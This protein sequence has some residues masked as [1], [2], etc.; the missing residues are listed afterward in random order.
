MNRC[1]SEITQCGPG[2]LLPGPGLMGLFTGGRGRV[3]GCALTVRAPPLRVGAGHTRG[4]A[5][6]APTTQED[7]EPRSS[8]P[9]ELAQRDK[10]LGRAWP[11]P[12]P[13]S[14]EFK[15]GPFVRVVVH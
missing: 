13:I 3:R 14:K 8:Q 9:G 11:Q 2:P 5:P 12:D 6:R 4:M 10:G 1:H 15:R 7:R